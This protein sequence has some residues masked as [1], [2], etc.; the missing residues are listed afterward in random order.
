MIFTNHSP[1]L[2]RHLLHSIQTFQGEATMIANNP[3]QW[4]DQ[5]IIKD[6]VWKKNMVALL[7][8]YLTKRTDEGRD[9]QILCQEML[10]S[11]LHPRLLTTL[12]DKAN[13]AA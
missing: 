10:K 3:L 11:S 2:H 13:E 7:R 12:F 1:F 5:G 8:S 9:I 6:E 4:A